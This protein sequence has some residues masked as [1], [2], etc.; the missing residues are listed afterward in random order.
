ML[1]NLADA[2]VEFCGIVYQNF[3]IKLYDFHLL[4]A[5]FVSI[6]QSARVTFD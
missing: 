1:M 2:H 3:K 4:A 5:P 6:V